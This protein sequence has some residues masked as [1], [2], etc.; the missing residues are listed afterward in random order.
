MEHTKYTA[1]E[2]AQWFL[3]YVQ[4]FALGEDEEHLTN[5]KLQK[6]L[7]YAQGASLGLYNRPLFEDQIVHW[8]HGPVVPTVYCKY[9]KFRNN[10]VVEEETFFD[11]FD[12]ETADLLTDVYE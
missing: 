4:G 7:Y 3:N 8:T 9:S 1:F 6:L 11:F 10:P 12:R 2:I 5:L